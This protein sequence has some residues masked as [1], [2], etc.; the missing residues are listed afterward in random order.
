MPNVAASRYYEEALDRYE[1][2]D[3]PGAVIQLKNALQIDRSMLP[4]QVLLGKA[5]LGSGQ[6]V[7]AE[8]ALLEALK[9]GVDRAEVVLPLAQALIAQGRQ[10]QVI[11]QAQFSP[12]GLPATVQLSLQLLRSAAA[13]D[14]GNPRAALQ[15]VQ[16]ARAIDARSAAVWL[17]EVPVRIRSRQYR[18]AMAAAER[19]LALAPVSAEALYQRGSVL[20]VTGDLAGAR[21]AYERALSA[22]ARHGESRVARAGLAFDL[23]RYDEASADVAELQRL[24]PGEPRGAYLE[25]L[26]ADRTGN[27]DAVRTALRRVTALID[28]APIEFIR[29]RPQMLMLNGLAHYG[30]GER[31]KAKP[32]LESYQRLLVN[33]AVSKLLAHIYMAEAN[34]PRAVEVLDAYVKANP[35]DG[36]AI[37]LLASAHLSQGRAA[38]AV[39]LVEEALRTRDTPAFHT[40]LGI[41]LIGAGRSADAT[42][43]LEAALKRDPAQA[44]AAA[45]LASVYLRAGA[46]ARAAALAED[47]VRRQPANAGFHH[48]L[49]L[50]RAASGNPAGARAAFEQALA[51][52]KSLLQVQLS[53]VRLDIAAKSFDAAA[54]RLDQL[55]T[56]YERHQ[57]V[58]FESAVLAERRGQAADALAWLEK[59]FAR[60][61]PKQLRS[62]LAMVD[63]HLRHGSAGPALDAAKRVASKAPDD[64][65]ALL[66]YSRAQLATGD[67]TAARATLGNA[68][69]IADFDAPLQTEIAALQLAARNVDGAAYS[70]DKALGSRPD[71]LPALA[72]RA[73]VD[74]RQGDPDRAEQ[75]ARRVVALSPG[76][77]LGQGLL[78]DVG[79]AR[80]QTAVATAAFRRAHEIEPSTLTLLRL[81]KAQWPVDDGRASLALA[82]RWIKTH[83]KD[84]VV[85]K[86]LADGLARAGNLVAARVAYLEVLTLAPTDGEAL[87]NLANVLL[88]LNERDAVQVAERAVAVRP[89][90][91]DAIDTLGWALF[92]QGQS[93]RALQ[94]LRDARLR[95]PSNPE[96]RF[97]LGSVLAQTGRKAAAQDELLA[98]L[99]GSR[100]F[101]GAADA[102][103]LLKSLK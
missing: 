68:T 66:A 30:L 97:H 79:M 11:D 65:S 49:G 23:G 64:L 70:L 95:D 74:L 33:T 20:H 7:A 38:K 56:A 52:D 60:E 92:R 57:D 3:M 101:S 96:I 67:A 54:A 42:A 27:T 9:L 85:H 84:A 13:S 99:Q 31:E 73:E 93:E 91:A 86:A 72:L 5:L 40:A 87:N 59:A 100:A 55:Q 78:G 58:L 53:L 63:F 44:Q 94:V 48:L 1:R 24:S 26:L 88:R 10:Q 83:P 17:A 98:A 71:F 80:G 82:E 22:D 41:S 46:P 102:E 29:Y 25:A 103:S 43:Q 28:P 37:T 2:R 45:A 61:G 15:S 21:A 16:D 51:L 39:A 36:E 6:A 90:N 76:G 34:V 32:Y 18:E 69:R 4:V 8:V 47:L 75:R 19:A 12:A 77:A 81:F 50:A 14:L 62:G 89:G 35:G